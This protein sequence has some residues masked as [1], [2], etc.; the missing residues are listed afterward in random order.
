MF[1]PQITGPVGKLGSEHASRD[2]T[3]VTSSSEKAVDVSQNHL[4]CFYMGR[5]PV[6][7]AS[8]LVTGSFLPDL[9]AME[10]LLGFMVEC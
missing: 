1:R 6:V 5:G 2:A 8:E 10:L 3:N 7:R 4:R 9:R